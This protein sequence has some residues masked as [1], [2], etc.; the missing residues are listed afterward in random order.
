MSNL[1][2]PTLSVT[3]T[4]VTGGT[5]VN[6]VIP[7]PPNVRSNAVFQNQSSGPLLFASDGTSASATNGIL[8]PAGAV[9]EFVQPVIAGNGLI[10]SACPQG[11]ISVWGATTGQQFFIASTQN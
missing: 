9:Y 8:V 4:I 3:G 11:S 1:S 10:I 2:L 5:A 7:D 6:N